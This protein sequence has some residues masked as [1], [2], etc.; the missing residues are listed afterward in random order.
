MIKNNKER[1]LT[2][3][4]V[5]AGGIA[6]LPL[7]VAVTIRGDAGAISL[8]IALMSFFLTIGIYS[9][10]KAIALV[11][12]GARETGRILS[13]LKEVETTRPRGGGRTEI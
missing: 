12:T 11:I 9:A 3:A 8:V 7:A 5:I 13:P 10:L 4:L 6:L 2:S 1:M